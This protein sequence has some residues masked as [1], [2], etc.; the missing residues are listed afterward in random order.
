[1]A[2]LRRRAVAGIANVFTLYAL[3][4]PLGLAPG[5]T[6]AELLK[7]MQGHVLASAQWIGTYERR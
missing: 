5:A 3:D 4:K 6:K 1:M 2:L 7:A